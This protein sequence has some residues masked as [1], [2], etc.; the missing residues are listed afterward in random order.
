MRPSALS[1]KLDQGLRDFAW[2]EWAQMGIL[3]APRRPSVWAQDPEALVVFTLEVGRDDPRL[4]D[5]LL[6]WLVVNESL[7]STR[8]LG[9]MCA[10]YEDERLVKAVTRW[11]GDQ[12][13]ARPKAGDSPA[14]GRL[15]PL[16]R[17]LSPVVADPDPAFLAENLLRPVAKPT[18]K[19]GAPDMRAPINFAFRLRQLLGIN[20]R[21]EVVRYLL[22][23]TPTATDTAAIA[24]SAGFAARNVRQALAALQDAGVVSQ[25]GKRRF[26]TDHEGWSRLMR[27]H[28]GELPAHQAWPQLLGGLRKVA[29]RLRGSDLDELSDY[30][31]GSETRDLLEV[32]RDEFEEAGF[33]VGRTPAAGAWEDLEALLEEVLAVLRV[34]GAADGWVS[35]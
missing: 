30:M 18:G 28:A 8:R 29:H 17:G 13:S 23:A 12:R 1:R 15:E 3:A 25:R 7:V 27:L 31:L 32:V 21:S 10:D 5:E 20:A 33:G 34:G 9:A 14:T 16:F 26:A 35:L 11:L 2:D 24:K 22:I 19:A 6:D 4:F